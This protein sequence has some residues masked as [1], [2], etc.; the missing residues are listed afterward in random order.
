LSRDI[1]SGSGDGL[2]DALMS[3]FDRIPKIC[4]ACGKRFYA[5]EGPQPAPKT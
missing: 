3:A 4:R 1:V 2:L 5:R